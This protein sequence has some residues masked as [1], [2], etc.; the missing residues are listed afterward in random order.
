MPA[1]G[2]DFRFKDL[3][4]TQLENLLGPTRTKTV[5]RQWKNS[6]DSDVDSDEDAESNAESDGYRR[7]DAAPKLLKDIQFVP[8]A[9]G[10]NIVRCVINSLTSL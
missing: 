8:W 5:L 1:P 3:T 4:Q 10:E 2:S 9:E 6:L 7:H